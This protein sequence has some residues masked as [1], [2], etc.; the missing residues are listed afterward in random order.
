MNLPKNYALYIGNAYP[1]KNLDFLIKAWDGI[2]LPLI[3]A[4]GRS[5]FYE[6]LEKKLHNPNIHLIGHVENLED[7]YKNATVFVFPTLME[8]FGLPPLEAMKA[9]VPVVA[10]DIPVL[11]EVLGNAAVFFD[12]TNTEDL[13]K[14]ISFAQTYR[15]VLIK[16][17]FDQ[18]K[19]YSWE[20][21]A[22][23]TLNVYESCTSLRQNK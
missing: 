15:K 5:V 3:L 18:V 8:G 20:R 6:H 14:K 12:P 2:K 16:K 4:G 9:G 21:M 22:R 11:R 13:K 10:S 19:K 23:E 1:H 7:L 17:G